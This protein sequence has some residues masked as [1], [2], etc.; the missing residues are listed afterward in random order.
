MTTVIGCPRVGA[1]VMISSAVSVLV[2]AAVVKRSSCL[3]A[4]GFAEGGMRFVAV[5]IAILLV[6]AIKFLIAVVTFAVFGT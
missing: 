6:V 5:R 4:G 1:L 3:T 2:G